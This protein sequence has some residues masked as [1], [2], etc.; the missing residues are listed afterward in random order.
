[1][2]NVELVLVKPGEF[3]AF[4]LGWCS[5]ASFGAFKEFVTF[6]RL[7]SSSVVIVASMLTFAVVV[8]L[9]MFKPTFVRNYTFFAVILAFVGHMDCFA[10][11]ASVVQS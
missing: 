10:S 2:K 7:N 5:K 8:M 1:M 9:T 4:A 3:V 6:D 11:L